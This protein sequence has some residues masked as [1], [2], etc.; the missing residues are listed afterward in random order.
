MVIHPKDISLKKQT[1][2]LMAESEKIKYNV[3]NFLKSVN[4]H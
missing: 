3:D 4:L 2:N 1:V